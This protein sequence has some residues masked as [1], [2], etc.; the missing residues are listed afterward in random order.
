MVEAWNPAAEALWGIPSVEAVGRHIDDL[1]E[2]RAVS[3]P[4]RDIG[5]VGREQGAW[6]ER[7]LDRPR[8]GLRRDE[9]I[10]VDIDIA[11][12][13]DK[14]GEITRFIVSSRDVT[15][16]VELAAQMSALA[17]LGTASGELRDRQAVARDALEI[18][19]RTT[20]ADDGIVAM[21]QDGRIRT[22]RQPAGHG[23]EPSA[24]SRI[25][26][27]PAP[28][29]GRVARRRPAPRGPAAAGTA[30]HPDLRGAP[31]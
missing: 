23:A 31:A 16:S 17:A 19:R 27:S 10:V 5:R 13:R 18:L 25:G 8:L 12:E 3:G 9:R 24:L 6:S 30:C 2:W 29:S 22:H 21:L 28:S 26:G 14:A 20:G 1:I 7:R 15:R 11:A 4:G